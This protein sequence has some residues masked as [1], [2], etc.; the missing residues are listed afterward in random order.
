[1]KKRK[2]TFRT[3]RVS[4]FVFWV[5]LVL[6]FSSL[7]GTPEGLVWLGSQQNAGGSFGGT[8]TSLATLVQSTSEVVRTFQTLGAQSQPSYTPAL[9]YLNADTEVNTEYLS[10]KTVANA[11]AGNNVT[12][13][14]SALLLNQ[15]SDGGFGDQAGYA[16]SNLDTAYAA[17]ALA[18]AGQRASSAAGFAVGFL[19]THQQASGGWV[20]GAND[21]SVFLTAHALRALWYYRN[22]Y[23]GVPAALTAART[24]LLAQRGANNLWAEHFNTALALIALIPALPDLSSVSSSITALQS[25]QLANGSWDNDPY[26][27]ALALQA[28]YLAGLPQ[29]NPDY[30]TIQGKVVDAQTGLPLAGVTATLT[31]AATG[32]LTTAANGVFVFPNLAAG[33]YTVQL[34]LANYA[35]LST[36]TTVATGQTVD[37]GTI[38]LSK[39][40]GATTGTVQGIVTDAATSLPL[41]GVSVAVTGMATPALTDVNG[42]YQIANVPAGTVAVTASKA[43]YAQASSSGTLTAGG[44]LVFSP[45]LT[46][47]SDPTPSGGIQGTVRRAS[48][49]A[50]LAGVS[51]QVTGAF[52]AQAL[53]DSSGNY[54]IDTGG[55]AGLITLSA[56][57][58]GY[59]DVAAGAFLRP[60]SAITFSPRL[61]RPETTPPG[62]NAAGII[63][64]VLDAGSN[65]PLANVA[66]TA[67]FDTTTVNLTSNALGR[68]TI[69]GITT[70]EASLRFSALGYVASEFDVL[71]EPLETQD[72]GQV[73]LRK[74][75]ATELLPD[76]T[77]KTVNRTVATTD[78]QTLALSGSLSAE[79]ANLGTATAPANITVAAFYDATRNNTFDSGDIA[80][81]QAVTSSEITVNGT[82][83]LSIPV[84][85]T[86]PFRDA[87]IHVFIDSTQSVV[88]LKENNNVN[89]TAS[90]CGIKETIGPLKPVVKWANPIGD[91]AHMPLV[92]PLIDTNGDG[93]IGQEDIPAIIVIAS[94]FL[95]ALSGKDGQLLWKSA[96]PL[97]SDGVTPALGDL[98][99]DG[100]PEIVTYQT[101]G[102]VYA[103]NN[104]GTVKWI[105]S[106]IS[107]GIPNHTA[108]T[109][110]DLDGDG[111][112]EVLAGNL[113]LNY[114][115]SLRWKGNPAG[116][117]VSVPVVVD[118]DLDG[119]PEVLMGPHVYRANGTLYWDYPATLASNFKSHA[120]AN[121]DGDPYP[122]IVTVS[123]GYGPRLTL[124]NHDG[125][126]KW[127]PVALS[128]PYN[129]GAP[130]VADFDGDGTLEIGVAGAT[131]YQVFN[132]DGSERWRQPVYDLS[133]GAQGSTAFDFNGDGRLKIAYFDQNHLYLFDGATGNIDFKTPN[134]SATWVEYPVVADVDNDGHAD[135]V[136][137]SNQLSGGPGTTSAVH[138]YKNADN[139]WPNTRR[140][141]NQYAYHVDNV[142]DDGTIPRVETPSWQTHNTYRLN[143][144]LDRSAT[145][146]PDLTAAVFK[147]LDNGT[148]Q[149]LSLSLRVGNAGAT[150][151]PNGVVTSFY[152]GDP[153]AGGALL[154]ST[155]LSPLATGEYR[156]VRVD[157]VTIP[158]TADLYAVVDS[159]NK[160]SECNEGNNRVQIP[161]AAS[162]LKGQIV[163]STDVSS[164][165]L[166][167]PAQL[168]ATATNTGALSA[169]FSATLRV[170]DAAGA[171]V[172]SFPARA[173]GPLAGGAS[174][175]FTEAWNTGTT[176]VGNYRLHGLLYD[177]AGVR[178][179]EA[180]AA[181]AIQT[182]AGAP[183]VT[184]RL[185]TDRATY[186]TTDTVN[187]RS[188]VLN[189]TTN[190]IVNNATLRLAIKNPAGQVIFTKDQALAQLPPGGLLD[191]LLPYGLSSAAEGIYTI[192]GKVLDAAQNALATATATAAFEV[193]SDPAKALSG[194]VQAALATLE[195]G[196]TQSCTD[197]LTNGGGIALNNL[198]VHH[199]FVNLD[200]QLLISD[201]VVTVSLA[202]GAQ[203]SD[204]RSLTTAGLLPGHYACVL[205]VRLG[206][207]LTT[208]AHAAFTLTAPPVSVQA[209]L[210]L[211][212]KARLLVLLDGP[213]GS[214]SSADQD[215]HGPAGAPLLSAQRAFLAK[216]LTDA[217]WSYTITE[218]EKDFTREFHSG[219]YNL[220]ALSAEQEKL[221]ETTQKELREAVFRGEGLLVAGPHDNRHNKLNDALGVKL[222]GSV[223]QAVGTDLLQGSL[224]LSGAFD[225]I[226]KD[227]ALRL[228]RLTAQAE[229]RYRLGAK[230][231]ITG[232]RSS[233][234]EEDCEELESSSAR[235]LRSPGSDE[236]EGHPEN[237]LD[238]IT[239]NTYGRGQ[240]LLAGFDGLATATRD[241]SASLTAKVIL[242]ALEAASPKTLSSGLAAV[243]PVELVLTNRGIATP[244]KATLPL[245]PAV[246]AVDRGTAQ[247]LA[248]ATLQWSL[249]LAVGETKVLKFWLRLPPAAATV[250]LTAAVDAG[251][252]HADTVALA[253]SVAEPQTLAQLQ[254]RIEALVA[255][256]HPD[257]K[258]LKQ[259]SQ[260]LKQAITQAKLDKAIQEVLKATDALLGLTR[261]EIVS[262]RVGVDEWLR[263][264]GQ[265]A[266]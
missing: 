8:A 130:L 250:S 123:A 106:A 187:I 206:G 251:S 178:V 158:G 93:K 51:I 229:A 226:P 86:L 77:V 261:P 1:M 54:R 244:V 59:E 50:P 40:A 236:C 263:W 193:K 224:D 94:G 53:T 19:L 129:G 218:N 68:F 266:Y 155:T 201:K 137:I 113:V 133:T 185:S 118:L 107:G 115:G 188:L 238:A 213:K 256:A 120:V 205:Q 38:L 222:I 145:A 225:L 117:S 71:I 183:V 249:A 150:T 23:Q 99:G 16:S 217:G 184:L 257:T 157:G 17:E 165:G 136:V 258:A 92:G 198:E 56:S 248:P 74:V 223:A 142:N 72:I 186:H 57:L 18:V 96:V 26:T 43:G 212:T 4:T 180:F 60:S 128:I 196:Q 41:Q 119:S 112:A 63:G 181:F 239:A 55:A 161:V 37:L 259:A 190:T 31:G 174:F 80:L 69:N 162:A 49:N 144:F 34:S 20:D 110:A 25:A 12:S 2:P 264:A 195:V 148:G 121:F 65:Q 219:G 182:P 9:N 164:Y 232:V 85:G 194:R 211:G 84:Q 32:T 64:L 176:L 124:M 28:L 147:I 254:A 131:F 82:L 139:S 200:T 81:G 177:P 209:E 252:F 240:A 88:E 6:P 242:A 98:D 179:H 66:I 73:R 95:N 243:V 30:A 126:I 221:N 204:T 220:Y 241:G 202:A 138:V 253:F 29:P 87:P 163:V 207:T 231:S 67:T 237:F 140:I 22:T 100:K 247:L 189:A 89:S 197:I 127:G 61:Y 45:A 146:V 62:T 102:T 215:P 111:K 78:P 47:S 7:A 33:S 143:A 46:Q 175:T 97:A 234:D 108:L 153:S 76:L 15:N 265:R 132:S 168:R 116:V 3:V 166:N 245:P 70:A 156:D 214:G 83:S 170:E 5:L 48:D 109:I 91:I 14:I 233:D 27:T 75:K 10:R 255:A 227:K 191:L 262:I 24:F 260:D 152:Q 11:L 122:E 151:A 103:F 39:T 79:L 149:P 171:I 192:D 199:A 154:A 246:E 105:S 36:T 21:P 114:D 230:A 208:L 203:N 159:N 210:R 167:A 101:N 160:V 216:L 44:V 228:K 172:V 135:L 58:A 173:V 35:S 134:S 13:L 104:D 52:S 169:S 125:S 42:Q 90:L 141:W 235:S